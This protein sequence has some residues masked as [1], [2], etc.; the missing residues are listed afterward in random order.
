MRLLASVACGVS[1][2]TLHAPPRATPSPPP[3]AAA[4]NRISVAMP[5][6]GGAFGYHGRRSAGENEMEEDDV[7]AALVAIRPHLADLVGADTAA[8]LDD[9]IGRLLADGPAKRVGL[10]LLSEHPATRSWAAEFLRTP[11][12][13][14]LYEPVPGPVV[15]VRVPKYV[16]PEQTC[17]RVWYRF[18][19]SEAVPVCAQ[20]HVAFVPASGT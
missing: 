3:A 6:A 4:V 20:H 7:V 15:K 2:E 9:R 17:T 13:L 14:R 1:A 11:P 8:D 18:S 12:Q 16:C 10:E 5:S 19:I